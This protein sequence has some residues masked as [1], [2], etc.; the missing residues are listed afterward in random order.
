MIKSL[1]RY[2]QKVL[3]SNFSFFL[4]F[5][6]AYLIAMMEV[7]SDQDFRSY[8]Y[9]EI[10]SLENTIES[11]GKR[12]EVLAVENDR[13]TQ[14]SQSEGS[15]KAARDD[16]LDW[17]MVQVQQLMLDLETQASKYAK[18]EFARR[19]LEDELEKLKKRLAAAQAEI[20]RLK[21]QV[22]QESL[23]SLNNRQLEQYLYNLTPELRLFVAQVRY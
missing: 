20:T 4:G 14:K 1:I 9:G 6:L 13:L 7:K 23:V 8:L 11:Q 22:E 17:Y 21:S 2:V 19:D 10:F 5:C 18:V 3:K 12:I 16:D 15:L